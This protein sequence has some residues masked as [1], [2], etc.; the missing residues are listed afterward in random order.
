MFLVWNDGK[1]CDLKRTLLSL[2]PKRTTVSSRYEEEKSDVVF[3]TRLLNEVSV[4][5]IRPREAPTK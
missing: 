1:E 5:E 3:G 2:R 4:R